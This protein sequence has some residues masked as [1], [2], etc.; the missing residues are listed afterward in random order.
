MLD[1]S[2]EEALNGLVMTPLITAAGCVVGLLYGLFG[3]GSS[4]ATPALVLL[5][6]PGMSAVVGP[7][8]AMLPGSAAG[9]WSYHRAG[10]ID[11]T[12]ARRVIL[13]A[14][15]AATIGAVASRWVGGTALVAMSG[16]IA[17]LVGIR[18]VREAYRTRA[19]PDLHVDRKQVDG[20]QVDREQVDRR[21]VDAGRHDANRLGRRRDNVV[22]VTAMAVGVGFASGLLANGGGFLLVPLFLVVLGLGLDEAAGTSMVVATVL[23]VPILVTHLLFG[24]FEWLVAIPFAVGLVPGALLGGRLAVRLP[25]HRMQ[26]VFGLLMIGLAAYVVVKLVAL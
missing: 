12:L 7:L 2:I 25:T 3:V 1:L 18:I 13:A 17:L 11:R 19:R 15:P 24:Q 16:L 21:H 23:T 4:F 20:K 5:G 10:R 6:V 8:P 22:L 26:G 9:A 14:L